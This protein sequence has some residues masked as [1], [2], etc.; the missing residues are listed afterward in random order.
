MGEKIKGFI[1]RKEPCWGIFSFSAL[2]C[3]Y[4][5]SISVF[6]TNFNMKFK[7]NHELN[8]EKKK[9]NKKEKIRAK[10]SKENF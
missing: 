5:H 4:A 7:G 3:C 2:K 6:Q 8:G 9:C 10:L 1:N